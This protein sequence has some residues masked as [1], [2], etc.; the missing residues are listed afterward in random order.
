MSV[1][2]TF[3]PVIAATEEAFGDIEIKKTGKNGKNSKNRDED[4]TN[5]ARVLYI[6]YPITSRKQFL[7]ALLDSRGEVNAIYPTF[8]KE[9]GLPIR[10][11]DIRLQKIDGTIIEIY[12]IIV[13]VF[14][15]TDK[16]NQVKFF[17]KTF[18]VLNVS[19]KEVFEIP[20]L[21]LSSTNI[22]FLDWNLC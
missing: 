1:L 6:Q 2:A 12:E 8:A 11:T 18:P 15:V 9:L 21:T 5:L 20:F 13:A 14:A 4:L 16:A 7:L 17:E 19:P 22:D 3:T 10:L